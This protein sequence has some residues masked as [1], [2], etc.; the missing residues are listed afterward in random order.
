MKHFSV[1]LLLILTMQIAFSQKDTT[2]Q[3]S[4][5]IVSAY[6]PV[7]ISPAKINFSATQLPVDT[8]RNIKPYNIPSQ[9]L[10]YAYQSITLNPLSIQ[11]GNIQLQPANGNYVKAGYGNLSS[12]YL[13]AA[14]SFENKIPST[15]INAYA[16]YYAAKGKIINQ[17]FSSINIGS[18]ASYFMPNSECYGSIGLKKTDSYLYGYDKELYTFDK[19]NI[20]HSF[21]T[22]SLM[23]GYK[24][25]APNFLKIN[26]N[27]TVGIDIFTLM[28][29]VAEHNFKIILPAS[30]R[31]NDKFSIALNGMIDLTK[32]STKNT[33][34]K[35]TIS[36][37]IFQ[38]TPELGFRNKRF[39][40]KVAT[41]FANNNKQ[42]LLLPNIYAEVPLKSNQLSVYAGWNSSLIKNNYQ[43][44]TS[45]NPYLLVVDSQINTQKNEYY[46]GLK[47][48]IGKFITINANASFNKYEHFQFFMNDTT[49]L[50]RSHYFVLYQED[51][52]NHFKLHG[53]ITY[54]IRDHFSFSG[55]ITFN[56]YS[57][58]K[59]N[60]KLWNTLPMEANASLRWNPK[61]KLLIKG[62]MYLFSAT[63]FVEKGNLTKSTKGG[64]DLSIGAE[65]KF[66][67]HIGAFVDLNNIFGES[68][69][70][71]HQYP[72]YGLNMHGG[73]IVRF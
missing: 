58:N 30:Y 72:V 73:V 69:E 46:A 49:D 19:S 45:I 37:N 22:A 20:R 21:T 60:E 4:V 44:L 40:L 71:W 17:N 42:S 53:D 52:L 63:S 34:V 38:I 16:N 18:A 47:T 54:T 31:I 1:F 29:S 56:A 8:F 55:G 39:A 50:A 35:H 25:T 67:K 65:Y 27:P 28:D 3:P 6:K 36:N 41:A 43:F 62:D 12:P 61:S 57:G 14:L 26:Y 11:N 59:K 32:Y 2:K 15:L 5:T 68:Y 51:K 66:N 23:L 64:T 13:D 7:L 70:R 10:H 9:N 33:L 48:S 24:N